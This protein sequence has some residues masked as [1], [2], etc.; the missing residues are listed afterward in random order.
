MTN[1]HH[2]RLFMSRFSTLVFVIPALAACSGGDEEPSPNP[3]P[4]WG[5]PISGGTMLVKRDGS[6]AVIADPDRDR[7][8][9]VDL[10]TGKVVADTALQLNDEP[11]RL[12]E[13]GTGLVHVAL[14]RG[15]AI[16][17]FD[18]ATGALGARRAACAEPRGLVWDS[19]GDQ[20]HVACS[21]GELVSFA[22]S[23]GEATR[24]LRLERDLRDVVVGAGGQLFVT[25]FRT[26]EVLALD[27]QGVVVSRVKPP[28]VRRFN[29]SGGFEDV[30]EGD[31]KIDAI[32]AVAY[33]TLALSDGRILMTHQRQLQKE[34]GTEE[35]GGYGGFGCGANPVEAAVTMVRNGVA[36]SVKP[37]FQGTL[38]VDAAVSPA[39]DRIAF[40][41]A[42]THTIHQ[43]GISAFSE[44]RGEDD[45]DCPGGG[46][47]D[48]APVINDQLGAPTSA[49][50]SPDGA[51]V[52][53]YPE[54]PAIVVH[55]ASGE[56]K[57]IRLPGEL[58]YDAGRSMFHTAT[59]VGLACASCH[60]EGLDDGL[61]W[62]FR[63]IGLRRTQNLAGGI[64]GRGPYHWAGDMADLPTLMDDV[65][66]KRMAGGATTRSQRI[67]LGPWL[68]RLPV[69]AVGPIAD[70]AAVER[71]RAIFQ[72]EAT[73][74]VTCHM[75]PLLTNNQLVN[76]GTAGN[77]KVPSLLGVAAR[78]PYM[79]DGCAATLAD[80]FGT[81]GGGDLHGK[82][83]QLD[84][85]QLA[86]LVA[87]LEAL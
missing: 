53:F 13:D 31:G 61:V 2:W 52:I 65:F 70:P 1:H 9:S 12:V 60:P 83:S 55:P 44:D 6:H 45:Q 87:Y 21:T 22:A 40:V 19:A 74:C 46:G 10:T 23:G 63:E 33:R 47:D 85:A 18:A 84:A 62:N 14:R 25:K 49:A 48:V 77:F 4:S 58:G 35:Q 80:R 30:P 67:S 51:L 8:V 39:G 38:P 56:P 71:G 76:V 75:G 28:T 16:V 43:V 5:V 81:C 34:L 64:L 73:G 24:R 54:F 78:A 50:Y 82:T 3:P 27:P 68:D 26:A 29:S 79:H 42:G 72:S 11:G 57:T 66:A 69:P 86:D 41:A 20:I 32:P 15:N 7:I 59:S 17:S 36:H 37:V